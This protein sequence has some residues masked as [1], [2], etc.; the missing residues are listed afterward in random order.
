MEKGEEFSNSNRY[1][2]FENSLI[3]SNTIWKHLLEP[4]SI[5]L[6]QKVMFHGWM[7]TRTVATQKAFNADKFELCQSY[8]VK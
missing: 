5:K 7:K 1:L 8:C 4:Q 2:F 6:A 3:M